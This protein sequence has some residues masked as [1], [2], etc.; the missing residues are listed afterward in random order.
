M[1]AWALMTVA[2][3]APTAIPVLASLRD[4]LASSS[5]RAWW[6]F[7]GGYVTV[8]LGFA[9]AAAIAQ[10]WLIDRDLFGQRLLGSSGSS[11]STIFSACLLAL[12]GVYQFTSL[13][14][15]CLTECV[16]PMT[17]FFQHW[18]DGVR[19]AAGMGLRHGVSC[20]GCC[21]A[22]MLLAFVGGVA[23]IW[24]MVLATAVMAVEKLPAVSRRLTAPLG[25][26]L[27]VAS[28]AFIAIGVNGGDDQHPPHHHMSSTMVDA[29]K[30][31]P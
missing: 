19:G 4:I 9:G 8:W 26:V 2:M 3:M 20:L 24:F 11:V 13:T 6:G 7:I 12:A 17:F 29:T 30:G 22:L 5:M 15:R 14:R 27:L 28:A 1:A 23:S 21:W 18:R 25:I 10:L 31:S 16:N